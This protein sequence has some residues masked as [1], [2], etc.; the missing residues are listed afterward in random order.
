MI[1]GLCNRFG[2]AI[3]FFILFP[4]HSIGQP[5]VPSMQVNK[6]Q[7]S[8]YSVKVLRVIE[9]TA[10]DNRIAYDISYDYEFKGRDSVYIKGIGKVSPK[11]HFEYITYDRVLE[12]RDLSNS[13]V[14]TYVSL[15]E[16]IVPQS[17]QAVDP[18]K[19]SDFPDAFSPGSWNNPSSFPEHAIKAIRGK[20]V[21]GFIPVEHDNILGYITTY[22]TLTVSDPQVKSQISI[23]VLHPYDVA[24]GKFTFRVKYVARDRPR[25]S[26]TW[27]YKDDISSLTKDAA[28]AFITEMI[29]ALERLQEK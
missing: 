11:G 26:D 3:S 9:K 7:G 29:I 4:L 5:Q 28:E 12:F 24:T 23:L 8:N 20:F 22:R 14:L 18:P 1:R 2:C 6:A 10:P 13:Q 21:A 16:T 15:Q 19:E 17:S 27:R 25:L